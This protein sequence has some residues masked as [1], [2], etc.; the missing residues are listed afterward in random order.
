MNVV[1]IVAAWLIVL[2]LLTG[3]G[4]VIWMGVDTAVRG[5]QALEQARRDRQDREQGQ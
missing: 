3:V 5:W 1:V 2:L 4:V